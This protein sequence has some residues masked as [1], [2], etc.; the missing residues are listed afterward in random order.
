MSEGNG[1]LADGPLQGLRVIEFGQ[2]LAGPYV[3][4]LLGD[5]GADV[6]KIEAPPH[7]DAVRDWG[8]LR[9]NDHSLWW[10]ILARNKKSVT[11]N[12]REAEGQRIALRLC[13][14]ADVV[15]ENFRPGT[16]EKWGLGPEDVHGK[17]PKAIYAGGNGY[18][19]CGALRARARFAP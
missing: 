6:V 9:H 16:M 8:R 14:S 4:T 18:G 12:L 7:G 3:G 17:N 5:F 13:E 10:S 2:L 15:L 19:Q 1:A 11:L